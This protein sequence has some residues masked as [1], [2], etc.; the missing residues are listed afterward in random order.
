MKNEPTATLGYAVSA[1]T[2]YW[3]DAFTEAAMAIGKPGEISG[4]VR[5]LYGVHVIYYMSDIT[6]G[7]VAYEEI[8]EGVER[9]A[10]EEKKTST[11][12]AQVAQWV[13]EA[14]PVYHIDRF[15]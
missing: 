14:H 15:V 11:Y 6:P 1:E 13:E 12:D 10:L 9:I 4:P 8:R 2:S 3:D 7:P 5:G